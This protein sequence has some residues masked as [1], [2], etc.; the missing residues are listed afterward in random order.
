MKWKRGAV[1]WSI[2]GKIQNKIIML[3]LIAAWNRV[4]HFDL[5]YPNNYR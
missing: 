4:A 1:F 5:D 3:A 2:Q